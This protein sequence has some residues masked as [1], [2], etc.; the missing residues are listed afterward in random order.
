M[1]SMLIDDQGLLRSIESYERDVFLQEPFKT[2][3]KERCVFLDTLGG[4]KLFVAVDLLHDFLESACRYFMSYVVEFLG[5]ET[6]R[7]PLNIMQSKL[8][9]IDYGPDSSSRPSNCLVEGGN[10]KLKASAAEIMTLVRYFSLL[11]FFFSLVGN[12]GS[13]YVFEENLR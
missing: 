6:K 2:G 5:Q 11:V 3:I 12:M 1:Q 13:V 4:F 8:V 9:A 10:L 7:V